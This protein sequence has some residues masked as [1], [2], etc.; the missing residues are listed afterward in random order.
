[1]PNSLGPGQKIKNPTKEQ[2]ENL[3]KS[4]NALRNN[5]KN[6]K[7]ERIK[8]S[9]PKTRTL[10]S[11]K[12]KKKSTKENGPYGPER[13]KDPDNPESMENRPTFYEVRKPKGAARMVGEIC[14]AKKRAKNGGGACGMPPG[15]G[16]PHPGTGR[17]KYHGGNAPTHL[18]KS[19]NDELNRL[20]GAEFEIDPLNAL[21]W[22]IRM[23]AG[24]T[25]YWRQEV[26]RLQTIHEQTNGKSKTA[27]VTN[28]DDN[29]WYAEE[30]IMGQ[31]LVLAAKKYE[32]AQERLAK[33]AKMALDVGLNERLVRAAEM[34][35]ELI[36]RLV[37]GIL[38]TLIW[39]NPN[40][41][42]T[43]RNKLRDQAAIIVPQKLMMLDNTQPQLGD[44]SL[45]VIE[46]G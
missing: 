10:P 39:D 43:L 34:Y 42:Q 23:S 1:M 13:W 20:L 32:Q 8:A 3:T 38:T 37:E 45:P 25:L 44:P 27:T 15:W 35:G 19:W 30:T 9:R 24:D 41:P 7:R 11:I 17:C 36:S 4:D 21:L 12:I 46:H 18:R 33:H 28:T 5:R 29:P 2:Q 16:T 6:R 31:Q 14:G 22:L 40:I 26:V